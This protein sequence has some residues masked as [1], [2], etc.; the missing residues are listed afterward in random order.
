MYTLKCQIDLLLLLVY[1]Q[2][3]M[4]AHGLLYYLYILQNKMKINLIDFYIIYECL[5]AQYK[6]KPLLPMHLF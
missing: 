5:S 2:K 1:Y 3:L 6:N 4:H